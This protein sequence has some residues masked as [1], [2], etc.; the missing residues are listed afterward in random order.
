M[1]DVA[2]KL[3]KEINSH[4]YKAYIVGGF[5]RDYLLQMQRLSN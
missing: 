5:V 2:L 4:S 1:L 3:L